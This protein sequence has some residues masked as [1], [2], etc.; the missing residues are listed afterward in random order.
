MHVPA[1]LIAAAIIVIVLSG[2]AL[3]SWAHRRGHAAGGADYRQLIKIKDENIAELLYTSARERS[4]AAQAMEELDLQHRQAHDRLRGNLR[5]A[6]RTSEQTYTLL[7]E[8]RED[9]SDLRIQR[10]TLTR[11]C[12]EHSRTVEAL[13]TTSLT[14]MEITLIDSMTQKLRLASPALHSAQQFAAAKQA[15]VLAERGQVLLSRLR[16]AEAEDAA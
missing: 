10:D 16:G 11:K 12:L 9:I 6:E 1:S 13:R 8:A 7:K 2:I 3:I 15:K 14:A 5:E 4:D